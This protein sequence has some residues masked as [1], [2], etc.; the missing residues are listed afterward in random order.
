MQSEFASSIKRLKYILYTLIIILKDKPLLIQQTTSFVIKKD[1]WY[2]VKFVQSKRK[3]RN[4]VRKL[5]TTKW[6]E[7]W[8][9]FERVHW[10]GFTG[11]DK[12]KSCLLLNSC[13]KMGINNFEMECNLSKTCFW[14]RY[15]N[16]QSLIHLGRVSEPQES[17]MVKLGL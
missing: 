8:R 10:K 15:W 13:H 9:T 16:F 7:V 12:I 11:A 4:E 6:E 5:I 14:G 3:L 17:A 2:L 1:F